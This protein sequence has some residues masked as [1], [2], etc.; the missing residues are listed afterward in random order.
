MNLDI[1]LEKINSCKIIAK[2]KKVKV[3]EG[4]LFV[5]DI[6]PDILSL[7][8]IDAE[9]Y[10]TSKSVR[11]GNVTFDGVFLKRLKFL[12]WVDSAHIPPFI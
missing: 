4:E 1:N 6:K 9:V 8:T 5:S 7:S 11:E 12:L 2:E 3:V 10:L